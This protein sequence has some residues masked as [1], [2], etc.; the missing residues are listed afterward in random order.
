M[1][2]KPTRP[3]TDHRAAYRQAL[4]APPSPVHM[5]WLRQHGYSGPAPRTQA[6]AS[7]L[8]NRLAA[9]LE[10]KEASCVTN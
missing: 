3:P 2:L 7:R 5:A 4:A 1:W 8:V 6:E 9:Q 10:G